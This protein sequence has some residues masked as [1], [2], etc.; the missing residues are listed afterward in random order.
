M[1]LC[2]ALLGIAALQNADYFFVDGAKELQCHPGPSAKKDRKA[3]SHLKNYCPMLHADLFAN[4]PALPPVLQARQKCRDRIICFFM[5]LGRTKLLH[6]I[7][8]L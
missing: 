7:H 6:A 2:I 5:S 8:V 1:L 4:K 3:S